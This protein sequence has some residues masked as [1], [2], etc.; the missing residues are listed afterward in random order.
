MLIAT[1]AAAASAKDTESDSRHI[2]AG[3]ITA[4]LA[5][6]ENAIP[7]TRSP[8]AYSVTPGPQARTTPAHS[9]P[10]PSASTALAHA[11]T[12]SRPTAFMT[13]R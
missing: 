7:T 9:R 1:G 11:S 4:W 5:H 13:S 8:G 6:A 12:G 10:T 2:L 3:R